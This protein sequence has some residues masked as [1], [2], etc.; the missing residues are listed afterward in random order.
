M[1]W[2]STTKAARAAMA[3]GLLALVAAAACRSDESAPAQAEPP[4]VQAPPTLDEHGFPVGLDNFKKWSDK[5]AQGAQPEGDEAFR[6]L[7]ALGFKTILTVDGA[8]PD[9]E[10]AERYGL[11]YVHVPIGYDGVP[12]DAQVRIVRAVDASDGPVYVHCHHGTA[13]GPAAAAVARVALEGATNEEA[14]EGLKDSGCA[15]VYKGLFRDVRT[16]TAPTAD[17]LARVPTNLPSYVPPGDVA[18]AMVGADMRF[19][20]LKLSKTAQ[21]G[22]PADHPDVDPPHEATMLWE[23]FKEIARLPDAKRRG[24]EFLQFLADA[25]KSAKDLETAIQSRDA[26]AADAAQAAVKKTCDACHAKYRNN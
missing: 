1:R 14:Y 23:Q 10:T 5:L 3:A 12:R 15:A 16:C 2:T 20:R 4:V 22:V 18:V 19:D 9:I 6:N 13:R 25:E 8:R 7:A 24:D 17:E 21:W 26:A 11:H